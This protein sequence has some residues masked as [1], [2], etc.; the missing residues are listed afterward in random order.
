M[1]L[2]ALRVRAGSSLTQWLKHSTLQVEKKVFAPEQS[3]VALA[4]VGA[5]R[6]YAPKSSKKGKRERLGLDKEKKEAAQNK[7]RDDGTRI[8]VTST[9]GN[10]DLD[11][12]IGL[13][14]YKYGI[15][16]YQE[17]IFKRAYGRPWEAKELRLK[18]FEDL[19]KLW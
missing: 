3:L 9:T 18:S 5:T 7:S 8:P 13:D 15:Q 1:A 17:Q 16:E 12:L 19:H 6:C 2:S 10:P 11:E 14:A 4:A